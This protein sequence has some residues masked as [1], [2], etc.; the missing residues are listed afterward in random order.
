M[1]PHVRWVLSRQAL[2]AAGVAIMV[3]PFSGGWGAASALMGGGIGIL[4]GLAYA[5]RPV[6]SNAVDPKGAFQAQV[7]GEA[8]K[9]LVTVLLFGA[10]FLGCPDVAVLPLFV[11]YAL[12][13]VVYWAALLKKR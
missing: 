13:F 7:L 4:A 1:H 9:F 10:V 12:T 2:V 3:A 5:W 11:A 8:Y 6:R